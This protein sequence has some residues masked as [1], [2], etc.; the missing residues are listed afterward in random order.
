MRYAPGPFGH[1][2]VWET[3]DREPEPGTGLPDL[4]VTIGDRVDLR[5]AR[6]RTT[7]RRRKGAR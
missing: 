2:P 1:L 5:P 6:V 7:S 4:A 3:W